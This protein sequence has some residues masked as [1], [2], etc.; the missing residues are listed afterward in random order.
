M[1][2]DTPAPPNRIAASH[3][4]PL[5]WWGVVNTRTLCEIH[6]RSY[7]DIKPKPK[8]SITMTFEEFQELKERVSWGEEF[9]IYFN[10]IGYWIS[11]NQKGV[12]FTRN[13]DG[14]TQEFIN[15]E[16]LFENAK[17]DQK[18]LKELYKEIEW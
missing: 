17:I 8:G 10:D 12:Y 3:F 7:K 9:L 4:V 11:R 13:N 2:P 1:Q 15:S 5:G 16:V 18:Y 6:E 14:F